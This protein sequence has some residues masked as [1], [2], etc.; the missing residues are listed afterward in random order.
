MF[1]KSSVFAVIAVAA[2]VS[3]GALLFPQV[4][5]AQECIWDCDLGSPFNNLPAENSPQF[6][7]VYCFDQPCVESLGIFKGVIPNASVQQCPSKFDHRAKVEKC[8]IDFVPPA[9][10]ECPTNIM[11]TGNVVAVLKDKNGNLTLS[12]QQR[13]RCS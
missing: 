8:L 5:Q 6:T 7:I 11:I 4:G 12:R 13:R 10:F 3:L 1:P 2:F 9:A